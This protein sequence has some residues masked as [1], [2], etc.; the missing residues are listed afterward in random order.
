MLPN[1]WLV[2]F[3]CFDKVRSDSRNCEGETRETRGETTSLPR[4][5]GAT[6]AADQQPETAATYVSVNDYA[7]SIRAWNNWTRLAW[8]NCLLILKLEFEKFGG[9]G[10]VCVYV[11]GKRVQR[12]PRISRS[13]L[14]L[15]EVPRTCRHLSRCGTELS[16][17]ELLDRSFRALITPSRSSS[18]ER[19]F[20]RARREKVSTFNSHS[21]RWIG[22][23]VWNRKKAVFIFSFN[24]TR[25][26]LYFCINFYFYSGSLWNS[27]TTLL[28][29][30]SEEYEK[31][32]AL[33]EE[34]GS[35]LNSLNFSLYSLYFILG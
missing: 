34:R 10:S 17:T 24:F 28:T 32:W 19:K 4:D 16:V 1:D 18:N 26:F 23:F 12:V 14:L 15:P 7:M 20:L 6:A 25:H 3:A 11:V 13:S 30:R 35:F 33:F 29:N 31:I 9:S 22:C 21:V 2:K 5:K 8:S 27:S